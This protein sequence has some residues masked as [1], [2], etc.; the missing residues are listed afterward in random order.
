MKLRINSYYGIDQLKSKLKN[1]TKG[2]TYVLYNMWLDSNPH[3]ISEDY[4]NI[5]VAKVKKK[6][7]YYYKNLTRYKIPIDELENIIVTG[8]VGTIEFYN[9]YEYQDYVEKQKLEQS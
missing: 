9:Q 4:I 5:V 2:D 8:P 3:I 7:L 1:P 6:H